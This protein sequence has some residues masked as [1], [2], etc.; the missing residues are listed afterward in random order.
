MGS[1]YYLLSFEENFSHEHVISAIY[2]YI[3]GVE[4]LHKDTHDDPV[5]LG[6]SLFRKHARINNL[7]MRFP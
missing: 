2:H 4:L 6:E 3:V 5:S 7:T 1:H